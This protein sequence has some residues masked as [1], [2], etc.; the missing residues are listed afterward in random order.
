MSRIP[1]IE[2]RDQLP[3]AQRHHWDD[4]EASRGSVRGPFKVMLHSPE[5]AGRAAHLGAYVRFETEATV[6]PHVREMAALITSRLLDCGYEYSAHVKGLLQ[7]GVPESTIQAIRDR[8]PEA[9]PDEDRWVYE[10]AAQIVE[11]HRV[12]D[13]TF[14]VAL[15]KLG[16]QGLVELVNTIG[17]YA[18]LAA[19]LNTFQVEPTE[20]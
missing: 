15:G 20:I 5:L 1:D 17:Y 12:S 10:L 11:H 16:Q 2:S 19:G 8:H 4:I 13:I 14:Q 7:A 3:E 6:P 9:L 18:F